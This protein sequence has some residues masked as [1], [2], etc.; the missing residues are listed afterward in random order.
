MLKPLRVTVRAA[1][2]GGEER[3]AAAALA[4]YALRVAEHAAAQMERSP[5]E[6]TAARWVDSEDAMMHQGL[7]W[8]QEH[9][10]ETA[11]RLA[12]ALAPWWQLRGRA[13]AGYDMLPTHRRPCG[14]PERRLA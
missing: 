5:E 14:R 3:E 6:L 7:S 1:T 8:A 12:L 10:Q 11:V 13:A 2:E 9:N 4:D